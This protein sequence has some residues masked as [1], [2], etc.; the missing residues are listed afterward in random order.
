MD[1]DLIIVAGEPSGDQHAAEVL[2]QL[3]VTH[4]H[5]K[6][7][8]VCGPHM[9]SAYPMDEIIHINQLSIMGFVDVLI[10]FPKLYF[11]YRKILNFILS[12]KAKV[13]VFV[14]YPGMNLKLGQKLREKGFQGQIFQYIAPTAWAWKKNRVKTLKTYCDK[15][16]CI[17]PFEQEFF[18]SHSVNA[19]YVGNPLVKKLRPYMFKKQVDPNLVAIFPGSR[20]HE[21]HKNLNRILDACVELKHLK[22]DLKFG[23]S[24]ARPE[25]EEPILKILKNH[26]IHDHIS[27]WSNALTI[28][29]MLKANVAIAKSGTCILELALLNTPAVV[30][31][32]ISRLDMFIAT[33]IFKINLPYYSLP[34]L[35]LNKPLL[36]ELYGPYFTKEA[37]VS[38]TVENLNK[39]ENVKESFENLQF[40]LGQKDPAL[41]VANTIKLSL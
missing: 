4:P 1:Y 38:A 2:K 30:I 34:N 9:K 17:L 35:I 41:E 15:L 25:L 22:P 39:S 8:G 23:L 12:H 20:V 3:K 32:A 10:N 24:I 29:L 33:K 13:V 19:E 28:D 21:I 6:I 16:F 11:F 31:Y 18:K 27:L 5:L 14:D 36:K 37:L 26:P 7:A 40:I